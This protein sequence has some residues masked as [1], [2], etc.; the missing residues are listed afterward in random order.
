[1]REIELLS[2]VLPCR[3]QADHIGAVLPRYLESLEKTAQKFE[4]I[5]V[6]NACSDGTEGI[7]EALARRDHRV[8]VVTN[9]R[10]GWGLS[11]RTGLEAARGSVLAYTNTARTDPAILPAFIERYQ[12]GAGLVKA[13]REARHA[14]LREIGSL[15]Y[16]LEAR[17]LFGTRCRDING[18]PKVFDRD[19]YATARLSES[20]DLVDLELM[21]QAARLAV[22]VV[23]I[24]LRGFRRHGG[25]SSTT[26]RSACNMYAGAL[27]MWFVQ[28]ARP[29]PAR[30]A[31][32]A[33]HRLAG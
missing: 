7:V 16:N 28:G 4:L 21:A 29:L 17:L 32:E 19:L 30:P 14:P 5:V 8:R 25:K 18:T 12:Q 9:P 15:L 10:G 26:L 27:R 20:G 31:G 33:V 22:S 13:C 24:P 23:E 3:N 6:P 1:M 11:V 2:L